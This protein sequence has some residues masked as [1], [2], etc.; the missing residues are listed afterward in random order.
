M[1]ASSTPTSVIPPEATAVEAAAPAV[2]SS[3]PAAMATRRERRLGRADQDNRCN[4]NTK[5]SQQAGLFHL[6]SSGAAQPF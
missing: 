3:T 5:N 4:Q 2:E 6:N 1:P